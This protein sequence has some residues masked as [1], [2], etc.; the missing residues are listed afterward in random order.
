MPEGDICSIIYGG[1]ESPDIAG[2][3]SPIWELT[4]LAV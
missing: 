1:E 4:A 2:E 3:Y